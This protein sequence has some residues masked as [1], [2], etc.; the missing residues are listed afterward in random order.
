M[1]EKE[2]SLLN[3]ANQ[4]IEQYRKGPIRLQLTDQNGERVSGVKVRLTQTTHNFLFGC[5]IYLLEPANQSEDQKNYQKHFDELFNFATLPFYWGSYEQQPGE[6]QEEKLKA[7]AAWCLEH[8]IIPKGHPLVWHSVWPSWGPDDPKVTRARLKERVQE[9]TSDF[10][11]LIR[12]W[13]VINESTVSAN[14]DNGL[15]EWVK[16]DGA[17]EVARQCL[18][19][20]RSA[21]PESVLLVN[22]FNVSPEYEKQLNELTDHP[23]PIDAIGIQSHM[24]GGEW[25]LERLWQV[26]E[27]YSRFELPVHFT[28]T[29]VLSGRRIPEGVPFDEANWE[30]WPSTAEGEKRQRKYV[31]AFYTILFSHPS[32]EAITWWDFRDGCWKNAPAGL[33]RRDLTP[34]PAYERLHEL[35]HSEWKTATNLTTDSN[36]EISL[37]GFYGKYEVEILGTTA[38]MGFTHSEAEGASTVELQVQN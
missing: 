18:E 27:D 9:I 4:R 22:D 35:I 24:H 6:K 2:L 1:N 31:E 10:R 15:G 36:G 25:E 26:C 13:D 21:A 7:M 19:W 3:S 14:F 29:T 12:H 30:D 16:Q 17:A 5:N 8:E 38:K 11:P 28:E 37:N 23:S 34:K 32:V 33:L 20:A